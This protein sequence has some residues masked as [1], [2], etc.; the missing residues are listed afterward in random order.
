[1]T[2]RVHSFH[3]LDWSRQF[4]AQF[5]EPDSI[6]YDALAKSYAE[7]IGCPDYMPEDGCI[8]FERIPGVGTRKLPCDCAQQVRRK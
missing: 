1:M 8:R 3:L 5:G 7:A 2:A 4:A 6:D